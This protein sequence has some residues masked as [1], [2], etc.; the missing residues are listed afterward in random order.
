MKL[1]SGEVRMAFAMQEVREIVALLLK[2]PITEETALAVLETQGFRHLRVTEGDWEGLEQEADDVPTG[3]EH[4]WLEYA[5]LYFIGNHVVANK[6]GRVYPGDV[7]FVL[8]GSP[9]NIILSREPD[10]SF[11]R[12][13]NVQP[14][15][16]FIYR[17]PDL[18]IEIMSPSQDLEEMRKKAREYFQYG[19][20][21]VW[22]V[23][24]KE[25]VIM[26]NTPKGETKRYGF[27]E[28]VP[29]GDLLPGLLLDVQ[30]VFEL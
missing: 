28:Q 17:A 3:E 8:D 30:A 24:P 14:T 1:G 26:T 12:R 18:A 13:E 19:T 11:V 16:G 7:I 23:L 25:K 4:G 27:G 29:G 2:R 15:K 10:V 21:Q 20:E 9:D 6:L 22:I 5:L